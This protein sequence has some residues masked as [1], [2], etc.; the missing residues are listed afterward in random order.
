MPLDLASFDSAAAR[1][2]LSYKHRDSADP[3]ID[4]KQVVLRLD[5][6]FSNRDLSITTSIQPHDGKSLPSGRL[7]N[8]T[9]TALKPIELV[10]FEA[11]YLVDLDGQRMLANGF[12]SWSQAREY[13]AHDRIPA[14]RSS[15]AYW[16]Q[17]NLQG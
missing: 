1:V 13:E 9:I 7:L 16:T 17:Y 3:A 8:I 12:Q 4:L 2:D 14:I 15:V 5:Q 11:K 10:H 6:P